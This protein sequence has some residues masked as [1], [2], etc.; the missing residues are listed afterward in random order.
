M[1]KPYY[2]RQPSSPPDPVLHSSSNPS[3]VTAAGD[4]AT[5]PSHPSSSSVCL[6]VTTSCPEG[7]L[8]TITPL[9]EESAEEVVPSRCVVEGR[10][11][12]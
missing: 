11:T 2:E 12:F 7:M 9:S 10:L 4:V 1:L 5:P 6:T 8:G 3:V